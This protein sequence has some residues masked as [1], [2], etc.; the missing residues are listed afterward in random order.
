MRCER[1]RLICGCEVLVAQKITINLPQ[2]IA[3][4][5][6]SR[7]VIVFLLSCE[8]LHFAMN[9][10]TI[11]NSSDVVANELCGEKKREHGSERDYHHC[12][13]MCVCV[14]VCYKERKRQTGRIKEAGDK[15]RLHVWTEKRFVVSMLPRR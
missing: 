10:A 12:V 3:V 14:C 7:R 13:C 1:Q 9:A 4:H 15:E 11:F 8:N 2:V 5:S 6:S